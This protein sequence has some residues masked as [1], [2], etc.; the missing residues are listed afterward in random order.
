[1]QTI[2][3]ANGTIASILA[4]ELAKY[5]SNIRLV[6]RNPKRVNENDQ[7]Y[8]ADLSNV[9]NV[10]KAIKGSIVV[11]LMVGFE[12]KTLV[13]RQNWPKLVK[14]TIEA[15]K[16]NN[17]KLV[18]FDNVYMY[19]PAD[20]SN[21]TEE[22][23]YDPKTKK[24]KIRA[25]IAQ[26]ILDEIAS[27]KL[28][29][30]IARSADFYGPKNHKSILCETVFKPLLKKS[31]VIWFGRTDKNHS[32]TYTPD[33]ARAVAMLGNTQDC[34]NQTWHLP[35][36]KKSLTGMKFVE[37]FSN[38]MGLDKTASISVLSSWLVGFL[39][40]F[41]SFLGEMKEMMYQYNDHYF[42]NSQKFCNRFPDFKVTEYKQ[43]IKETIAG[44][45]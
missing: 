37:L 26:M 31:N 40:F 4:K 9:P 23:K 3:G 7:L 29:A 35:T 21:M 15:C 39:S 16:N 5:T 44:G 1:M 30:I 36:D 2:L 10:E 41:N 8:P 34:Y 14:A 45:L 33:A 38:E 32:F 13:W 17:S 42:F 20:I 43:G 28:N 22:T 19:N 12:Y 25:E 6:S 24:G 27:G 11:Y 18:F